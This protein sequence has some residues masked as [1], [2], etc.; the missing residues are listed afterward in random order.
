MKKIS[1]PFLI[2]K[3]VSPDYFCDRQKETEELINA[4][5]NGRNVTLMSNRRIGKTGLIQNTIYHLKKENSTLLIYIDLLYTNN[6]KEFNTAFAKAVLGKVD[7]KI[8]SLIKGFVNVV[9]SLKP[10]ITVD[11]QTGIP[12]IGIEHFEGGDPQL[13]TEEIFDYLGKQDKLILIAFDEFQQ[14]TNYPE[15]NVEALLRSKTQFLNNCCFIF[16][17]SQKHV[18]TEMFNSPKRPFFQ[19]TQLMFLDKI[20]EEKYSIFIKSNFSKNKKKIEPAAVERIFEISLRFTYY[21]QFL[22]NKLYG[23]GSKHIKKDDV[24]AELEQIINDNEQLYS[25]IINLLSTQQLKLLIAIALEKGIAMPTSGAFIKKHSLNA[26]SSVKTALTTLINKEIL[27][28][29]NN[30]YFVYDMFFSY[31][32]RKKYKF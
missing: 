24:D 16:S 11:A 15:K 23:S 3:Y 29:E 31:F 12:E 2:G 27:V 28:S 20:D 10:I 19:S 6:L 5:K 22:C 8:T 18:I 17:G 9:K 32:L 30:K 26:A 21:V 4:F 14:I 25:A 1:N 7:N 13:S